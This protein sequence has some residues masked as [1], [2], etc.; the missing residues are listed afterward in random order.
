MIK[1][2]LVDDHEIIRFGLA[3]LFGAEPDIDV[4]GTAGDGLTG[5]AIALTDQPDVVLMDVSMPLL[6]GLA[7]TRIIRDELPTTRVLVLSLYDDQSV[8]RE[9]FD[10]GA[11]GYLS[12]S[13]GPD[14]VLDAVRSVYRGDRRVMP[15]ADEPFGW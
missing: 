10:A 4:I 8:I 14:S 1:L 2:L 3:L 11:R 7:A 15:P 13:A 5:V 12:K 6:D 9:A